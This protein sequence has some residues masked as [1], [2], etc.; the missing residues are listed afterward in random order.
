MKMEFHGGKDLE[1][2]L[3]ELK[4]T[5]R[6]SLARRVLK[7][8]GKLFA[9]AAN[10]LAPRGAGTPHLSGSYGVSTRL[11][12][13]QRSKRGKL[14]PSEVVMY[15]GTSDPAGQQ[16]EFGNARHGPQPHARPAFDETAVKMLDQIGED[17]A[18]DIE[19]TTARARRKA[20][21]AAMKRT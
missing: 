7:R 8:A 17:M 19:K 5:A 14:K 20:E 9:D 2:A 4:V 6:K 12:K 16:Q 13:S 18:A 3:K 15:A 21:R 1:Q 10:A 11:N